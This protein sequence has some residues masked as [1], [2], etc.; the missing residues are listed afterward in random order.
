MKK[1]FWIDNEGKYFEVEKTHIDF[2]FENLTL[3]GFTHDFLKSV[4]DKH[5]EKYRFE[6]KARQEIILKAIDNGWIRVRWNENKGYFHWS[7]NCKDYSKDRDRIE[8]FIEAGKEKGFIKD[9]DIF[10]GSDGKKFFG[11][12]FSNV[13]W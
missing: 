9:N 6:G 10:W 3:F 8:K 13:V 7:I 4:Y 11:T 2:I 12:E 5:N 1:A